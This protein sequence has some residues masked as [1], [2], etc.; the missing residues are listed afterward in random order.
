MDENKTRTIMSRKPY[1][2]EMV[3]ESLEERKK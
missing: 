1:R 3:V 2:I